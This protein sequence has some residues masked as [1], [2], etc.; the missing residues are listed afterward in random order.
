MSVIRSLS[1]SRDLADRDRERNELEKGF[2][3]CDKKLNE[4]VALH[5]NDLYTVC[6]FQL[7]D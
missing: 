1:N 5:N 7:N 4:L 2:I 6:H 3:Q